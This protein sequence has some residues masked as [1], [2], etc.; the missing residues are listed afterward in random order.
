MPILC[1]D[2]AFVFKVNENGMKT[3]KVNGTKV[4]IQIKKVN[5]DLIIDGQYNYI[6]IHMYYFV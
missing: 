6:Y 3:I 4:K 5:V 2:H 1:I